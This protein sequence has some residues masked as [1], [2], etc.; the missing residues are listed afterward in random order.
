MQEGGL[1]RGEDRGSQS[2]GDR[3][4]VVGEATTAILSQ[5]IHSEY[6]LKCSKCCLFQTPITAKHLDVFMAVIAAPVK[7]YCGEVS[8]FDLKL[9]ECRKHMKTK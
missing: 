9:N 8:H 1:G 2:F 7:S 6:S 3:F 4:T 5:S